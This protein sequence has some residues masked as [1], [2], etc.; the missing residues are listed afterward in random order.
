MG[1]LQ[2]L[3]RAFR[4]SPTPTPQGAFDSS[5]FDDHSAAF[6]TATKACSLPEPAGPIVAVPGHG[7]ARPTPA[8]HIGPAAGH[9]RLVQSVARAR[10]Q[11]VISVGK[12]APSGGAGV[13]GVDHCGPPY[14]ILQRPVVLAE[15]D[16][17]K[18][19]PEG[20]EAQR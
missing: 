8:A 7:P 20:H 10:Y 4:V 17:Q 11:L 15:K 13:P 9:E 18:T 14:E 19:D 1:G 16:E 6:Q 3:A 5:R 12:E 2:A